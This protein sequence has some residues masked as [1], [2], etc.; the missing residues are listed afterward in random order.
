MRAGYR[1]L[2]GHIPTRG[3]LFL[4]T[5]GAR[6]GEQRTSPVSF[7]RTGSTFI[8]IATSGGRDRNPSWYHN[9]LADP[10]VRIEVAD[11]VF[12]AQAREVTDADRDY[13]IAVSVLVRPTHALMFERAT[14]LPRRVPIIEI[15]PAV[16]DLPYDDTPFDDQPYR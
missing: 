15:T 16:D 3:S 7:Q 11:R 14:R 9:I 10:E 1:T 6:S 13:L 12:G 2:G 4:T 8:V 5:T